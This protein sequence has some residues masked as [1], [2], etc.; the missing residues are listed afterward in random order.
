[1]VSRFP[2]LA[3]RL[4]WSLWCRLCAWDAGVLVDEL[5][6]R[7]SR[8]LCVVQIGA[9][10]GRSNDPISST[11]RTRGWS[12]L[13]VEPLPSVF[14]QLVANYHGVDGVRFANVAVGPLDDKMKIYTVAP[15][16][17]D[18]EWVTQIAS[19]DRDVVLRHRFALPDLDE[20]IEP[21]DIDCLRIAS[22]LERYDV[23]AIDVLH[24]DAEGLDDEILG[25]IDPSASWAPRYVLFEAKH[26]SVEQ[27]DGITQ[28]LRA[29][30][31]HFVDLWPD[32]FAYRE[33]PR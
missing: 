4:P 22:L 2:L 13:L 20:R 24:V 9:N 3:R 23:A 19:L 27:Y 7:S 26:M 5:G 30:G 18:P 12:G 11:L 31:Y 1:M 32:V 28:H 10:D 15:R 17:G 33:A 14:R 8:P 25:Q 21:V 29:H 16:D 6:R